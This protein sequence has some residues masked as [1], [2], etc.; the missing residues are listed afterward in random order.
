[1]ISLR[2]RLG[3]HIKLASK[4]LSKD[5]SGTWRVEGW[6]CLSLL[7]GLVL[8]SR[9]PGEMLSWEEVNRDTL[10]PSPPGSAAA[11]E[12]PQ[13]SEFNF[14]PF[15]KFRS[16]PMSRLVWPSKS[17]RVSP[18]WAPASQHHPAHPQMAWTMQAQTCKQKGES[19]RQSRAAHS[20]GWLELWPCKGLWEM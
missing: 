6:W 18:I 7:Q 16:L 3:R 1:M 14:P 17:W 2:R 15:S 10:G 4:L 20:I 5:C 8:P 12:E 13:S 11:L 9:C 19:H